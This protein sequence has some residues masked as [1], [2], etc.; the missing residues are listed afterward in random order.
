MWFIVCSYYFVSQFFDS[1]W[2][3]QKCSPNW[4]QLFFGNHAFC[5]FHV[6]LSLD[7][8]SDDK[9]AIGTLFV[10]EKFISR[11]SAGSVSYLVKKCA[12]TFVCSELYKMWKKFS[13]AEF[14][15]V[16]LFLLGKLY[17]PPFTVGASKSVSLRIVISHKSETSVPSMVFYLI[18][19]TLESSHI[20]LTLR[21]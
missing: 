5:N 2:S 13:Q 17:S 21:C 11:R 7:C 3:L 20:V 4:G 19:K 18:L 1:K 8:S 14:V 15:T 12:S 10:V 6:C 16:E 9:F